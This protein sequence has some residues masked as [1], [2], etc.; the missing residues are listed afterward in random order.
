MV[1]GA[2]PAAV[3]A[4]LIALVALPQSN[5]ALLSAHVGTRTCNRTIH[6]C[7]A[8]AFVTA[9]ATPGSNQ[10]WHLLL[11]NRSV[12]IQVS[13]PSVASLQI[14][15]I[16]IDTFTAVREVRQAE[17]D[18]AVGHV[19]GICSH[20][21]HVLCCLEGRRTSGH[22]ATSH[23]LQ[24]NHSRKFGVFRMGKPVVTS[25]INVTVTEAT[26][27]GKQ[28]IKNRLQL[29]MPG[30]RWKKTSDSNVE[31]FLTSARALD[32]YLPLT[33]LTSQQRVI[34]PLMDHSGSCKMLPRA[35][36]DLWMKFGMS[37]DVFAA[38]ATCDQ[39]M[40]FQTATSTAD[41]SDQFANDVGLSCSEMLSYYGAGGVHVIHNSI[42]AD[43]HDTDIFTVSMKITLHVQAPAL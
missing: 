8:S 24:R 21:K 23:C 11:S 41:P 28:Q 34:L 33:G 1:L 30:I 42:T 36:D 12:F 32:Q 35:V 5:G 37:D 17:S 40:H 2:V 13:R 31:A 43:F 7:T 14:P 3:P 15:L 29:S 27:Q 19:T 18:C 25:P 20:S 38:T 4:V 22:W 39:T 26:A 9:S 6:Q 16:H 10:S